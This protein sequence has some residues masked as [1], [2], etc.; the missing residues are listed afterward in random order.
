MNLV[1]F[2]EFLVKGIVKQPDLVSVKKFDDE[3]FI[4]IQ[5]LV[6]EADMA[7]V[8]GKSGTTINSIRNVVQASA[9]LN[10]EKKVKINVD[11][12]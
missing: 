11:S 9:I 3:E 8:I 5:V 7:T 6:A 4:T 12:F 2:T 1:E 10:K